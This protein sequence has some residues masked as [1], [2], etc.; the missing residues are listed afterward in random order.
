MSMWPPGEGTR[1]TL[2]SPGVHL[3]GSRRSSGRGPG[4]QEWTAAGE[5]GRAGRRPP[6]EAAQHTD[7]AATVP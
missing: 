1:Q 2:S 4:P 5:A 7:H 6:E 3:G